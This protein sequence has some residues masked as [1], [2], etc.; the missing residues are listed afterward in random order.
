M[1]APLLGNMILHVV[2]KRR[3]KQNKIK[4][5]QLAISYTYDTVTVIN[6]IVMLMIVVK[7]HTFICNVPFLGAKHSCREIHTLSISDR[8]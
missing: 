1:A 6:D 3:Q 8:E 4:L 5:N 2:M 7:I